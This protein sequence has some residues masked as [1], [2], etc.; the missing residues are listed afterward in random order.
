MLLV[1]LKDLTEANLTNVFGEHFDSTA[2]SLTLKEDAR[3]FTGLNDH[4]QSD[5]RKLELKMKKDREEEQEL[6]VVAKTTPQTAFL[7]FGHRL[8]VRGDVVL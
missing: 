8:P 4:L 3:E 1:S 5:I 7:R 6:S 2:L